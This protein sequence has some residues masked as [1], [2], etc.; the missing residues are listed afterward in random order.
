MNGDTVL[1]AGFEYRGLSGLRGP[2]AFLRGV[3]SAAYQEHVEVLADDGPPRV[4]RV[5]SVTGDAAVVE[6]FGGTSGL[7]LDGCRVRFHGRPLRLGVGRELLGRV[8]DGLGRPRDGLPPP[9]AED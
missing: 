1:S 8:F 4:G 7:S 3:P 5:L 6:V 9:L 2:L